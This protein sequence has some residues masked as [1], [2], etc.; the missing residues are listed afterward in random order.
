MERLDLAAHKPQQ[1]CAGDYDDEQQAE[2][3]DQC[4]PETG[5]LFAGRC[6]EI[7]SFRQG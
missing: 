4:R 5:A 2:H 3:N 7:T 1:D 6:H